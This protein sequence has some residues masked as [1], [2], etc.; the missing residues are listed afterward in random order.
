MNEEWREV[1]L[2]DCSDLITG[3]P[4]K[5]SRFT[6][7]E[8]DIPLVKGENLHQG[9]IDWKNA[10]RWDSKEYEKH[11]KY[12]LKKD[13]VLIAMDRPWIK[14][15]LKYTWIKESDPKALLV[16]R[17][18]RLRGT[19][20]LQTRFLRYVIGS[21]YFSGYIEPIVT[22][23]N[24][25]HISGSQ[26][27]DFKFLLP[28]KNEQRKIVSILSRYDKLIEN[29]NR[30]IAILD[31]MAE[32]IYKE[33]FVRFRFPNWKETK[34]VDG[35]PEG[36]K[37]ITVSEAFDILGGGTPSKE[38]GD[39]WKDGEINWYTPSD[40]TRG[41]GLFFSSSILKTNELG[42]RKSSAK[43]IPA[44]SVMMTSRATIGAVGINTTEACTNQGFITCIPNETF[45]YPYLLNWIKQTTTYIELIA[46]GA[47]F[48]EIGRTEFKKL[49]ICRPSKESMKEFSALTIP[50]YKEI[51]TLEFKNKNLQKTRDLLLPRLVSGKLSVE[52]LIESK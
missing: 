42:L 35:I 23:V 10:K 30:R 50:I 41:K 51:E 24:V 11:E 32:E 5:S 46:T 9:Y 49:K 19:N 2:K 27:L 36:W 31:E 45:S 25:P 13:D 44:Y 20:G 47:T 38:N 16:Q 34:V 1:K 14:A 21:P 28:P 39:Y 37:E 40:I 7:N 48:K 6:D 12:H 52:H 15:G 8:S 18:A 4:F 22:G 29:N 3:F 26:I 17:V 43:L 33:W